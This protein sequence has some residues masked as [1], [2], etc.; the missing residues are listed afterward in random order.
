MLGFSS[1]PWRSERHLRLD[2]VTIHTETLPG[3]SVAG[4]NLGDTAVHEVGH[5]MG[6][7]HTFEGGCSARNDRVDDTP[8]EGQPSFQC[9]GGAGH[10]PA[11]SRAPT[12]STTSWT[13]RTTP[14]W[15]SSRP[16]RCA[17]WRDNWLAYR[18]P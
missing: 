5:W 14:A 16:A 18:T 7:F 2:G 17:G 13:T 10:L 12:R 11:T 3:G 1:V 9:R 8:A 15:T 4:Y 6:L